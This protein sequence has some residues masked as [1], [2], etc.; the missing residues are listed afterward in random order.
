MANTTANLETIHLQLNKD[1]GPFVPLSIRLENSK[2]SKAVKDFRKKM[3]NDKEA[4]KIF[5]VR[6]LKTTELRTAE[7]FNNLRVE[8]EKKQQEIAEQ[9]RE[10]LLIKH[11]S[12][13]IEDLDI[14][15]NRKLDRS[16]TSSEYLLIFGSL[17]AN[18]IA[19]TNKKLQAKIK[20]GLQ[21]EGQINRQELQVFV[22]KLRGENAKQIEEIAGDDRSKISLEELKNYGIE[23]ISTLSK[24][25]EL[26]NPNEQ[27]DVAKWKE[28]LEAYLV[29]AAGRPAG[30]PDLLP[31]SLQ[32][33]I[34]QLVGAGQMTERGM[35]N[36]KEFKGKDPDDFNTANAK[37]R[38]L[39]SA[40]VFQEVKDKVI[41]DL[42]EAGNITAAERLEVA[43]S[44]SPDKKKKIKSANDLLKLNKAGT[45]NA[46]AALHEAERI[47][48]DGLAGSLGTSGTHA[49]K[50]AD[51]SNTLLYLGVSNVVILSML[52]TLFT[53][54][55]NPLSLLTNPVFLADIAILGATANHWGMIE[56]GSPAGTKGLKEKLKNLNNNENEKVAPEVKEWL[57]A[58]DPKQFKENSK[59]EQYIDQQARTGKYV[60]TDRLKE[61]LTD[62]KDS[63]QTLST[64]SE[65]Q[66][67]R[68]L[69]HCTEYHID[70]HK[71]L[72]KNA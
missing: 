18:I 61:F 41:A 1:Q 71:Y 36:P 44:H 3:E 9:A 57:N 47:Q 46:I 62:P 13:Y 37:L 33:A 51:L 10:K 8:V 20:I 65:R 55:G 53:N 58:I 30:E 7:D 64:E 16:I 26:M 38:A 69:A 22:N 17:R 56:F 6:D 5:K 42:K 40:K 70:P 68:I 50:Y 60:S 52:I 43:F 19:D 14:S 39:D 49:E 67:F 23:N 24:Y 54:I 11:F 63:P 48:L 31:V 32:L 27:R 4:F 59:L 15:L 21:S 66:L 45:P 2:D 12:S 72:K 35:V 25:L 29:D 28:Q 34:T